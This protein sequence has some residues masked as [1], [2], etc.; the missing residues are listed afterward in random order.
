LKPVREMTE[1]DYLAKMNL[2]GEEVLAAIELF[3]TYIAINNFAAED[4]QH[5]AKLKKAARF[6]TAQTYALQTSFF[7]VLARIFDEGSGAHSVHR[8]LGATQQHPEFFTRSALAN[9]KDT[10]GGYRPSWADYYAA[11]AW[12][13]QPPDLR[14][15]KRYLSPA[16]TR[17][18][19]VY[20]P[21]RHEVFAHKL[22]AEPTGLAALFGR[23]VIGEIE[24]V[25]FML[26]DLHEALWQLFHNGRQWPL[27]DRA[28][29]EKRRDTITASTRA[30]LSSL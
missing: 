17:F 29:F 3:Y 18:T 20:R 2:I 19:N 7:I 4:R 21:L 6:W 15:F 8:L 11:D 1:A 10:P 28:Q 14:A 24:D 9:R 25:L 5:F 30:V 23:A 16:V 12:E 26:F 27:G 13:P 22:V